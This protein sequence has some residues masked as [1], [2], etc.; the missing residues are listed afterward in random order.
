MSTFTEADVVRDRAGR[1]SFKAASAPAAGLGDL[2]GGPVRAAAGGRGQSSQHR[3]RAQAC[4]TGVVRDSPASWVAS[5]ELRALGKAVDRL[6]AG[7]KRLRRALAERELYRAGVLSATVGTDGRGRFLLARVEPTPG[8][9][10]DAGAL[11]DRLARVVAADLPGQSGYDGSGRDNTEDGMLGG[12]SRRMRGR[13]DVAAARA[14]FDRA[15]ARL[16]EQVSR[17]VTALCLEAERQGTGRLS[18]DDGDVYDHRGDRL[19]DDRGD[20]VRF[21]YFPREGSRYLGPAV[22]ASW[23]EGLPGV[24]AGEDDTGFG[25]D[26]AAHL[27]AADVQVPGQVFIRL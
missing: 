3:G 10:V 13:D 12:G 18:V 16:R 5:T 26:V 9:R 4:R 11:C 22:S 1:F 17:T 25:I 2:L 19:Y 24:A 14:S 23:A 7:E 6:E 8:R 20:P 27:E 21:G 15:G